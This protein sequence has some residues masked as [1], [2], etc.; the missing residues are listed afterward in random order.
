MRPQIKD[1]LLSN[2]ISPN[3]VVM[4]ASA[5]AIANIAA[6]EISRGEWL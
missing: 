6:I 4:K 1:I 5:N 3:L 2:L